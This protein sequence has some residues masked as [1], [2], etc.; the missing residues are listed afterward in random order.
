MKAVVVALSNNKDY[1][2]SLMVNCGK[3][4]VRI[5][6]GTKPENQHI[7]KVYNQA[8][9]EED[10]A[11]FFF[12]H[13]DLIGDIESFVETAMA[14]GDKRDVI[15]VVG[16]QYLIEIWGKDTQHIEQVDTLDECGFGFWKEAGYRF[17]EKLTWTN[18]S[19][20][21]CLQAK[22]NGGKSLVIP[23][24]VDHVGITK[25]WFW[26]NG[27]FAKEYYYIKKKWG[28]FHRT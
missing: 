8:L 24:N 10:A 17:D 22:A 12:A 3:L 23:S 14:T 15:G 19:Q 6:D 26:D 7:T 13:Q 25:Q 11:Y 27:Y 4:K 20:D 21:I 1:L 16:K 9:D 2:D 18:Y 5:F 28:N